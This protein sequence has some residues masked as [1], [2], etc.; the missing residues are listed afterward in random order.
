MSA[1]STASPIVAHSQNTRQVPG[2]STKQQLW[3][4]SGI[5]KVI[6]RLLVFFDSATK[7]IAF[8]LY[9]L[10]WRESFAFMF[11]VTAQGRARD[12]IGNA[13]NILPFGA[14]NLIW[15]KARAQ[16]SRSWQTDAGQARAR[17]CG[18]G[19]AI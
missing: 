2:P 14:E 5:N 4:G 12:V 19:R 13:N 18:G 15:C 7:P 8:C 1:K 16:M 3:A 10:C 9:K 17:S 6:N 11:P